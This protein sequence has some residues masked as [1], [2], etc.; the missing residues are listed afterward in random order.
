MSFGGV[1]IP[2]VTPPDGEP[3]FFPNW[4]LIDGGYFATL[5]IPLVA[6][7]DFNGADHAGSERVAIVNRSA[8][9]RFWPGQDPIGRM[10]IVRGGSLRMPGDP[11][12]PPS[13]FRVVGVVGDVLRGRSPAAS[14]DFYVPFQQRYRPKLA[15]FIRRAGTQS[16]A[17]EL[18][19][20]VAA[21]DRN[22]PVLS[23]Q[24]L[25][26]QQNGPVE[27]QLRIA[28]IVAA[29]V[30]VVGL[31]LA[32]IGVYGVTA[33]AVA[34]RTREIGI[35]LSLGA[36][37][38]DV[39][40]L[41]LRQGMLLVVLGCAIGLALGAAA[42]QVLARSPLEVSAPDAAILAGAALLF[43]AI[44]LAACYVPVRRATRIHATE[45]LRYE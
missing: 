33:H 24:S 41:V 22:L 21:F 40:A 44:G 9:R 14:F 17:G 43:T 13:Q 1:T 29:S 42:G 3:F 30:G 8:A 38:T 6:G 23:A 11:E 34:R 2:G 35:R 16:R 19:T 45:A 31:L 32:G 36:A 37:R 26:D 28:A 7:R 12:P 4:L 5:G 25:E 20:A 27:A 15:L 39:V 10:L 18:Q